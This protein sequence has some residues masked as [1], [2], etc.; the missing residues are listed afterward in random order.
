VTEQLMGLGTLG[1]GAQDVA[2]GLFGI[3]RPVQRE[4]Y[5][6]AGQMEIGIGAQGDGLA[7]QRLGDGGLARLQSERRQGVQGIRMTRRGG[8]H[9]TVDLLCLRQPARHMEVLALPEGAVDLL[10]P[11]AH[12]TGS[13]AG[14]RKRAIMH[15][16]KGGRQ[17]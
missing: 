12:A 16:E 9:L 17:R 3:L 8:D 13:S 1:A 10:R 11:F 5:V 4:Q 6:G 7:Q 2:G 14:G 15:R